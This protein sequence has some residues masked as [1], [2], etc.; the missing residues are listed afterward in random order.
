MEEVTKT[1]LIADDEAPIR[2]LLTKVMRDQGLNILAASSGEEALEISKS[3]PGAI[4]L[5]L[6]DIVMGKLNGK[7]LADIVCKER[8][9][10]R[11]VFMSGYPRDTVFENGVCHD[12]LFFLQKP[13]SFPAMVETVMDV[14][15]MSPAELGQP[16]HE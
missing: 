11:V 7:E 2:N 6:T 5:L 4:H 1:I 16:R 14:L 10:M 9:D 12:K 3:H 15:R 13:F 8:T